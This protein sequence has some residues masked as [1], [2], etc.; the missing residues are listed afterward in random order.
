MIRSSST[1]TQD[2]LKEQI[3]YDPDTGHLTWL[4]S[5]KGVSKG[6]RVSP[7]P[8]TDGYMQCVVDS[9]HY[10]QH[11][12]IW[13]WVTGTFPDSCIDHINRIRND[14]RWVNL[15]QATY[16]QNQYNKEWSGN[17]CGVKNVCQYG[18]SYTVSFRDPSTG[19]IV[20]FG[21]YKTLDEAEEIAYWVREELHGVF[22]S[23]T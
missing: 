13:L 3:H 20:N 23:H 4:I 2:R 8:A 16:Y 11:Q 21:T 7:T 12:I 5:K 6:R 22:A 9:Q 1:L 10:Y 15:R 19:K 14:N 17:A 18:N